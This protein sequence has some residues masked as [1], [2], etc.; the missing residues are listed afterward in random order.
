MKNQEQSSQK[1]MRFRKSEIN[2]HWAMA[3]PFML[4]FATAMVLVIVYNPDPSRPYRDAVSWVHRISGVSLIIFPLLS[5][6]KHRK[7]IR[8]YFHNIKQAW[9]WSF[10]DLK[11][12]LLMSPAAVSKKI[13]LPEQG[14]FNAAEKVNFMTLTA[15]YP[16]YILTGIVIWM[17]NGILLS[18]VIHFGMAVI[19]IPL[20]A[21]HLFMAMVNPSSRAALSGMITGFVDRQFV[22]HHHTQW[23][24]EQFEC[25]ATISCVEDMTVPQPIEVYCYDETPMTPE[26][27]PA[28]ES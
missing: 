26:S 13:S 16:L 11:W 3:V 2:I 12:L 10:K 20:V 18:W 8:V 23:Y 21:G 25:T 4:C 28:L 17:T 9:T 6:I 14:K 1:I 15:T 7:D 27:V 22:E 19:A 24:R 5:L